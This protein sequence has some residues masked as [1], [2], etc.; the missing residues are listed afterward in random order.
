MPSRRVLIVSPALAAANNGNWRTASRYA[1]MLRPAFHTRVLALWRG[2]PADV[3]LALHARRSAQSIADW[4]QAHGSASLGLVL[5][6]TDLYRDLGQD[7]VALRSLE[8][9]GALVVLQDSAPGVL[10]PAAQAK[11][12]VIYQSAPRRLPLPRAAA[13]LRAL[14]V[15][16]LRDE[17][18]PLTYLAA[19]QALQRQPG[20]LLDHIGAALDPALG[21]AVR[22]CA[23]RCPQYRW[24]GELPHGLTRRHIARAHVLVHPSRIE[25]GAHVIVE[26]VR[27]DTPVLASRI[28]G[29]VGMLGPDYR[30]YFAPG[31]AAGLARL[32]QQCRADP[33]FLAGLQAQCAA[34]EWLFEPQRER[35]LLGAVVAGLASATQD[36]DPIS[37]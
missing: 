21:L 8:L 27:S 6:G 13:H 3:L 26:A 20:I 19:A 4:A 31:D 32:L 23:G 2:E 1:R 17:K 33:A 12:H 5:T 15:G 37:N 10:P 22:R 25:G 14:M 28:D 7:P 29:N 35:E 9:A 11:A 18:D 36:H 34:R 16:H 24:L 30:G